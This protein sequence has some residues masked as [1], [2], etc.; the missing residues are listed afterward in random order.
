MISLAE[1]PF[2]DKADRH[3]R[4]AL[5]IDLREL[6]TEDLQCFLEIA[7]IHR[8]AA[9][10]ERLQSA[11]IGGPGPWMVDEP[12]HHGGRAEHRDMLVLLQHVEDTVGLEGPRHDYMV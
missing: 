7:H 4:L 9:E 11:R 5:A 3:G 12:R 2:R 1:Q 8:S 10:I 6:G